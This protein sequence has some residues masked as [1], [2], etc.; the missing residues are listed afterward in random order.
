MKIFDFTSGAKGKILG[1]AK[2]PHK[3][4]GWLIKKKEDV[5]KV[6]L[7]RAGLKSH[8]DQEWEWCSGARDINDIEINPED[9]GVEAVCFCSGERF[10]LW[11]PGHPEAESH[12]DWHVI[13]TKGWNR[14]ACRNGILKTTKITQQG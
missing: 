4:D 7:N 11:Y 2:T 1:N 9:F 3:F 8:S 10:H 5:F 6:Q 13:G 12:W 14:E